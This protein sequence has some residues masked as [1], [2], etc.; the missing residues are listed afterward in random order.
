METLEK[1]DKTESGSK[2][3]SDKAPPKKMA[4]PKWLRL[5]IGI[6]LVIGI[7][8]GVTL[9]SES[10]QWMRGIHQRNFTLLNVATRNL[11][12][13]PRE[14]ESIAQAS[15]KEAWKTEDSNK[16][17]TPNDIV[18][19]R[20]PDLGQYKIEYQDGADCGIRKNGTRPLDPAPSPAAPA[21]AGAAANEQ[22][23]TERIE[24]F[25]PGEKAGQGTLYVV[26]G[27]HVGTNGQPTYCYDVAVPVD[28][29]VEPGLAGSPISNFL[30]VGA[31]GYIQHQSGGEKLPIDRLDALVPS[32]DITRSLGEWLL[33][34]ADKP[35]QKSAPILP[36][37]LRDVA[38]VEIAGV[39]YQTYVK[40]LGTSDA[41]QA[42]PSLWRERGLDDKASNIADQCYAVAL[43][44]ASK[45]RQAWLSPSPVPLSL[46][47]MSLLS[48]LAL[49][50]LLRLLLIG[51]A[52]SIRPHELFGVLVGIPAAA[53][54]VTLLSLFMWKVIGLRAEA[55]A[56][57]V[58]TTRELATDIQRDIGALM[59]R[60]AKRPFKDSEEF[61]A[62]YCS[63]GRGLQLYPL[64]SIFF[65]NS[66]GKAVDGLNPIDCK[67]KPMNIID[68][69]ERSY[70]RDMRLGKTQSRLAHV[71]GSE[72][73]GGPSA[74]C[75]LF[76]LPPA[77]RRNSTDTSTADELVYTIGQVRAQTDG[78]DRTAILVKCPDTARAAYVLLATELDTLVAPTLPAPQRFMVVDGSVPNMPVL[79]HSA[80][81]HAGV[82]NFLEQATLSTP[83]AK[84]LEQIAIDGSHIDDKRFAA[85]GTPEPCLAG[86][87]EIAETCL[88]Q[89]H[90][91]AGYGGDISF[92]SAL[93]IPGT[94]W[95]VLSWVPRDEVD[96]IA[97]RAAGD[98]LIGWT[99]IALLAIL[100]LGV[101]MLIR[102]R[103]WRRYW[104]HQ[105]GDP[106]YVQ[107]RNIFALVG[108]IAYPLLLVRADWRLAE[109]VIAIELIAAAVGW[110]WIKEQL[111]S[112]QEALGESPL[113]AE[114]FWNWRLALGAPSLVLALL[115]LWRTDWYVIA[116]YLLLV[117]VTFLASGIV[118]HPGDSDEALKP[119]VERHFFQMLLAIIVCF[120]VI[121]AAAQ[122]D[123]AFRLSRREA[124]ADRVIAA[125]ESLVAAKDRAQV[126]REALDPT[127]RTPRFVRAP[128]VG[129]TEI[130]L[131]QKHDPQPDSFIYRMRHWA[132]DLSIPAIAHCPDGVAGAQFFCAHREDGSRTRLY[133]SK[134][135]MIGG[136][137]LF[138][139]SFVALLLFASGAA[140]I[141]WLIHRALCALAGFRVPLG[142]IKDTAIT[143]PQ[144]DTIP[145]AP[146]GLASRTLLIA[147]QQVMLDR[148]D[149]YPW[150]KMV[151]LADILL[152][153]SERD[154]DSVE[155]IERMLE[156]IEPENTDKPA[157]KPLLIV[158]GLELVLRDGKR[159]RGALQILEAADRQLKKRVRGIIMV[160][161]MS[162]LERILDAFDSS[163]TRD[164]A[165]L[166]SRE[167]LRWSRLF[168]TFRTISFRPI[169][170][171]GDDE[172]PPAEG[173]DAAQQAR[174]KRLTVLAKELRWLPAGIIDA[175]IGKD[176]AGEIKT[177]LAV[178]EVAF[179]F[180]KQRLQEHYRHEIIAWAEGVDPPSE[181]AAVDYMRSTLIE[182]YEQCWV[183]STRAERLVLDAIARGNFVNMTNAIAL[184]SLVRRG[185]VVLDPSPRLM[186]RSFGLFIEQSERPDTLDSWRRLQPD[187]RWTQSRRFIL[188]VAPVAVI[189]LAMSA[190]ETGEDLTALFSLLA[191]GAP[192]L[193]SMV[194]RMVR[195]S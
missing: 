17:T 116:Y 49:L 42:C 39:S 125:E 115:L 157:A 107:I 134:R 90:F 89:F 73:R 86:Q 114:R 61:K 48:F 106:A 19:L 93:R 142:A 119:Q 24:Y 160:A 88:K 174:K 122:W 85:D 159:R 44:P 56:E 163:D 40:P 100:V 190:A 146:K 110:H 26:A 187:S 68:I 13:W 58:F 171:F 27:K 30:I 75:P 113:S 102:G 64:E 173:D 60:A 2:P 153:A 4:G 170:K 152:K 168:Q 47:G 138:W 55:R 50:P 22:G 23:P 156:T 154:L 133:L 52:E 181:E 10:Q 67:P 77:P 136:V 121:P 131:K 74:N 103:G 21:K 161:E 33:S 141:G 177:S 65:V 118:E 3:Q 167:E 145:D 185:L 87:V 111:V 15:K 105:K 1:A 82:E 53:V 45:L 130:A 194:I 135:Q 129:T 59:A 139:S 78:I 41:R 175:T 20:H 109:P 195:P 126:V 76:N 178:G 165:A 147:P 183:A 140:F 83:V 57:L 166:S 186:S 162:P 151:D 180:T 69:S 84:Q 36:P 169:D 117:A 91:T 184:Q 7:A 34:G 25:T 99:A 11:E 164:A 155:R 150:V 104:P 96:F 120:A 62:R 191:A 137:D 143:L 128:I 97:A 144:D 176:I 101:C 127:G 12:D 123:D 63:S 149:D 28:R 193:M 188:L 32:G 94:P 80:Q 70:F 124:D 35:P 182:H 81:S 9:L 92:F 98:A 71:P 54:F 6:L 29:L 72:Q 18:L 192:T 95:L 148:L 31:D 51:G 43:M 132:L 179:P 5:A 16:A 112:F 108:L 189:L 46:F 172:I 37:A 8:Y 66:E 79:F 38:T 158:S 14:M